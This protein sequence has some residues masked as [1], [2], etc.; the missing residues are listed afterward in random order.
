LCERPHPFRTI[1]VRDKVLAFEKVHKKLH[2]GHPRNDAEAA[3]AKHEPGINSIERPHAPLAILVQPPPP[4]KEN[5]AN[6][7]THTIHGNLLSI[8][9]WSVLKLAKTTTTSTKQKQKQ[10]QQQQQYEYELAAL[11]P[12][13]QK[14][15]ILTVV[16]QLA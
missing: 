7:S 5:P 9:D 16:P 15:T 8:G 3:A 4:I 12:I 11:Q 14:A 13:A 2:P 6:Q 1:P 10:Q